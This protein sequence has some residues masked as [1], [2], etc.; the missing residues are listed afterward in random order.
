[1]RSLMWLGG[2][3]LLLSGCHTTMTTTL[4]N[5]MVVESMAQGWLPIEQVQAGHVS[6]FRLGAKMIDVHPDAVFIDGSRVCW[7]PA[8]TEVVRVDF[9]DGRIIVEA[10]GKLLHTQR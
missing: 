7:V 1:M 10:D 8:G 9:D 5:G 4:N 2:C 6:T 3:L